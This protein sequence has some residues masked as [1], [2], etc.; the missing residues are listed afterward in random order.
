WQVDAGEGYAG[1]AV[2]AGRVY[3]HDYDAARREEAIRCLSLADGREIWRWTCPETVKRNHGMTRTVPAIAGGRLLALSPKCRVTCLEADTGRPLWRKDLAGEFGAAVPPW[4]AGQCPLLDGDRAVLAP[5]GPD[6]LIFAAAA[7]TGEVRWRTPNPRAWTMTHAS[8]VPM[9]L[10]GR[11]TYV[12][13]GSGGVA[14]VAADT[15]ELLWETDAW[16]IRIATVPTPLVVGPDRL[17]LAGGYDAGA[18]MLRLRPD[19]ARVLPE[20]EFRLEARVFGATQQTPILHEDHIYGVRP[21]GEAVCLDLAGRVQWTSGREYRF[22]LGPFLAAD[23]LL[24]LL[25]EEG[26]L[27]LAEL[28]PRAFRPLARAQILPGPEAWAPLALAGGRLLARDLT[29]LV[30][31]DLTR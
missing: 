11:S 8:V 17:F 19:G 27:T 23:G 25:G 15:G 6:T 31:L 5:G 24:L 30:C 18:L 1:V 12:V 21:D 4:Y 2:S 16:K 3:L 13:C 9:E 7:A 10:L 28:D 22:G 14:G 26:R 20:V 29:R